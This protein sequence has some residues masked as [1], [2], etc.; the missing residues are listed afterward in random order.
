MKEY[1]VISFCSDS[2]ENGSET[3]NV[4][5]VGPPVVPAETVVVDLMRF[6]NPVAILLD[7]IFMTVRNNFYKA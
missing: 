3:G 5:T 7:T 4:W 1:D 6:A 2:N